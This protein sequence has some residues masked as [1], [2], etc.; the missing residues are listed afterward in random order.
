MDAPRVTRAVLPL[1]GLGTRF[2]PA[3]KAVPKELLPLLDRPCLDYIVAEAV[4]AGIED[5]V[6]VLARGK[7]AIEDHFS[8][9]PE[10]ERYLERHDKRALLVEVQRAARLARFVSVRQNETLGLGHA[11]YSA[12]HAIGPHPFAVLLGDDIIHS[13]GRPGLAQ[14]LE[15][16]GETG[17]CVVALIEVPEDQTHRY[18]IC[19]G[20]LTGRR[21]HVS[22]MVEKPPPGTAPSRLSIVGRY[23]LPPEIFDILARTRPGSGGEIQL[24][25]ALA[26][27]AARGQAWGCLFEGRR[28]DTGNVLGWLEATV[29]LALTRPDLAPRVREILRVALGD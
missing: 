17:G 21:M 4:E 20:T 1:A 7:G 16:W 24:T 26:V 2:L 25:D 28:Y 18:G 13:P 23:I 3:T 10:L 27:L 8:R 9:D 29:E 5:M 19:A 15:V 6:F 12:R 11:V 14:L 22:G